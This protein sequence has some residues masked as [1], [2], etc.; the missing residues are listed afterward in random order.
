MLFSV[1]LN[2][3]N[4][5]SKIKLLWCQKII[6][7]ISYSLNGCKNEFQANNEEICS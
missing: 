7:R 6:F 4:Q 2:D 3:E 1:K 5:P